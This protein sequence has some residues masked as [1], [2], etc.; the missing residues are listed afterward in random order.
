MAGRGV[1]AAADWRALAALMERPEGVGA[2]DELLAAPA[3]GWLAA[4]LRP[5]AILRLG[6]GHGAALAALARAAERVPG[7][8]CLAAPLDGEGP[9]AAAG[10]LAREHPE[11]LRLVPDA[12]ARARRDGGPGTGAPFGR[13]GRG[14]ARPRR[15]ARC[16]GARGAVAIDAPDAASSDRA[17]GALREAFGGCV[18]MAALGGVVVAAPG[19]AEEGPLGEALRDPAALSA[20]LGRMGRALLAQALSEGPEAGEDTARDR[21]MAAEREAEALRE[22][23]AEEARRRVDDDASLARAMAEREREL[24]HARGR[25]RDMEKETQRLSEELEARFREIA[26]LTEAPAED[27]AAS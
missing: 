19:G 3:L 21:A 6:H 16:A 24:H 9:A 13:R 2:S 25:L 4:A 8:V 11:A 14:G 27:R 20:L 15:V 10:Q 17:W 23:L 12:A 1:S 22:R 5:R 18:P 26:A 7:A